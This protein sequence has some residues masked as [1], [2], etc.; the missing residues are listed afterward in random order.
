MKLIIKDDVADQEK[1]ERE[2]DQFSL[3]RLRS[4]DHSKTKTIGSGS[5]GGNGRGKEIDPITREMIALDA[6]VM[7]QKDVAVLHDVPQS[8]VSNA[9][10]G[11]VNRREDEELKAKINDKKYQI[12]DLAVSKL[13][14][15]L[16]LFN[17]AG[18]D[19]QLEVVAAADRLANVV[20]KMEDRNTNLLGPQVNIVFYNPR[21]QN[22]NTYDIIEVGEAK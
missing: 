10:N 6:L 15:T 21:Q 8:L 2:L 19:S 20:N 4:Q 14:S 13:M 16:D 7:P 1:L 22:E 17:P 3:N 11:M 5:T 12:K 9:V 18:L